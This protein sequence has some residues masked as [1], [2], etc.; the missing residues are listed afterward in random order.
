MSRFSSLEF[1]N[2]DENQ[3]GQEISAVKDEA[4]FLQEAQ[5]SF[6]GGRFEQ[7]LRAYSKVLEFNP[8]NVSAWAGQVRMLI[9]LGE[10]PE[11]KLWADKA[12]EKF[13]NEPELLAT[14]AVALGRLGDTKGAL[15]F[16]D[17]SMEELGDSPY[18]WL[19][20]GDVL[21]ARR[22]DRADY[23]FQKA[24]ALAPTDWF[25]HWLAARI[26]FYYHKFSISLQY[27]QKALNFNPGQSAA[28]LQVGRCQF[29]LGLGTLAENSLTQAK[30]LDP[31]CE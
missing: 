23:C 13:P 20:R 21:L 8:K 16:S 12:I 9:E 19:A 17:A 15:A 26:Y 30:Q 4:F 31:H 29:E 11:A 2:R 6:E 5:T 24:W 1:S 22:E 25:T 10:F 7:A 18:V 14:K 27:A 28:W 3:L